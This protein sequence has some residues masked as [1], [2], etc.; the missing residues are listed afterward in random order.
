MVPG[1]YVLLYDGDGKV[2]VDGDA[3]MVT[4]TPGRI[5]LDI[6]PAAGTSGNTSH[7]IP[8]RFDTACRESHHAEQLP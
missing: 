4:E 6:T 1:Q 8:W 3:K 5:L 2:V 7:Y